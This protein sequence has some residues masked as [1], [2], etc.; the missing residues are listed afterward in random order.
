MNLALTEACIRVGLNLANAGGNNDGARIEKTERLLGWVYHRH[1][2]S[3]RPPGE[4]YT[5]VNY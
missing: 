1:R 4:Y 3:M 5:L 2:I